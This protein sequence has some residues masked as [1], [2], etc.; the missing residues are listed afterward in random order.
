MLNFFPA[1]CQGIVRQYTIIQIHKY[2]YTNIQ[3]HNY[4]NTQLYK[5]TNTQIHKHKIQRCLNSFSMPGGCYAR[6][7][8]FLLVTT[9]LA[10]AHICLLQFSQNLK[11][12]NIKIQIQFS[13]CFGAHLSVIIFTKAQ[14]QKYKYSFLFSLV[15]YIFLVVLINLV[16]GRAHLS[17]TVFHK[18]KNSNT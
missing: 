4:T 11:Y 14:I 2:K 12:T 9:L 13:I 16:S 3:I 1:P 15:H 7:G 17:V 8:F 6:W 18:Y 5:Y 10:A